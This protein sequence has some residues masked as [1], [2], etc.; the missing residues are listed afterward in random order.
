MKF[1]FSLSL[2]AILAALGSLPASAQQIDPSLL[3]GTWKLTSVYDEFTDG[4]RRSTWGAHPVGLVQF[5]PNGLF[6]AQM[7]AADRAPK[8]GTVPTDP[9]G[10]ALAYYGTYEL[11]GKSSGFVTHI[12]QATWPQWNGVKV[13]R[14]ITELSATTLKLTAAPIKDPQGGEFQPHLEFERIK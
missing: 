2:G 9:V 8:P 1:V 3:I 5:A 11:D 12:Q 14:T 10:P 4:R 7:M 13:A 6:S